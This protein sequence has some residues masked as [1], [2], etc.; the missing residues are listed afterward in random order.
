MRE[1]EGKSNKINIISYYRM[2]K[3]KMKNKKLFLITIAITL[4]CLIPVSPSS[5]HAINEVDNNS[6]YVEKG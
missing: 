3:W 1:H 5:V 2:E 4:T 6:F